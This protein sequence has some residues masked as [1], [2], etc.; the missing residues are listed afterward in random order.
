MKIR[1][2]SEYFN[3]E[4]SKSINSFNLKIESFDISIDHFILIISGNFNDLSN[5]IKNFGYIDE[6][7]DK[8]RM[9][10]ELNFID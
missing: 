6:I 3:E 4:I 9:M 5:F 7:P 8:E 10:K 1:I 2:E